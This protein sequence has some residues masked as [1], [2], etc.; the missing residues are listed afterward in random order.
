MEIDTPVSLTGVAGMSDGDLFPRRLEELRTFV[1]RWG[2]FP[3]QR[4]ERPGEKELGKW[5]SYRK[6]DFKKGALSE[7]RAAALESVP[8][9]T[10]GCT[11]P[12]VSHH[13]AQKLASLRD[14]LERNGGQYPREGTGGEA[15]G[16]LRWVT[17]RRAE[18]A[19]GKL[20]E[21]RAAALEELPGWSWGDACS[22]PTTVWG[23]SGGERASAGPGG[24]SGGERG[25]DLFA[26][27]LVELRDFVTRHGMY[28]KQRGKRPG[29][30][31]LGKWMSYR[32]QD[33]KK[34]KLSDDK[35]A[36]LA[37]LPG[38]KWDER[39]TFTRGNRAAV[40]PLGGEAPAELPRR[41]SLRALAVRPASPVDDVDSSPARRRATRGDHEAVPH[42]P[43]S[44]APPL[45]PAAAPWPQAEALYS[46]HWAPW[47]WHG[48][49]AHYAQQYAQYGY[50]VPHPGVPAGGGQGWAFGGAPAAHG[51]HLGRSQVSEEEARMAHMAWAAAVAGGMG[52]VAPAGEPAGPPVGE[53]WPVDPAPAA[54]APAV[55]EGAGAG[56]GDVAPRPNYGMLDY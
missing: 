35:A 17:A 39:D 50:H 52:A 4:G 10:W 47:G 43:V 42:S 18:H 29:E 30:K 56:P 20:A 33:H 51:G 54:A 12:E 32:R 15:R 5:M 26:Q 36:A 24:G 21:A 23:S 7:E 28:P 2:A 34:G 38:W 1:A 44:P 3:T 40:V 22:A 46:Q 16:L 14:F 11:D 37:A 41:R 6:Q 13:F 55:F 48:Q 31:D 25:E 45:H 8:G 53:M 27:R 49:F 9:W 19:A